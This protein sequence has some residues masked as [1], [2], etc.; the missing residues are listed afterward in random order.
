MCAAQRRP[1]EKVY[2]SQKPNSTVVIPELFIAISLIAAI[3]AAIFWFAP[4][5]RL[6]PVAPPSQVP[7]DL[8]IENLPNWLHE[9]EQSHGHVIE[10]AEATIEWADGPAVTDLCIL[11]VHGFSAT[12]QEIAP[13]PERVAGH[14]NANI[15][16]ARLAGHGLSEN[17]MTASAEHWLQ[18]M[19]DAWDIA[20]RIGK[21]VVIIAVSTGAPLSVWLNEQVADTDQVHSF[22]FLSPNF[23][24]RNPF[25]FLLTWPWAESWVPLIVGREHSWEPEN[26]LA[27]KYWTNRYETR[28]VIEM[29]KVVDWTA[30]LKPAGDQPP[31]ATLY[32]E[33]DP[34]I[35]HAAAVAFHDQWPASAKQ[36]HQVTLDADNPQHVF[37]GDITAPHRTDW[38]VDVCTRFIESL[39]AEA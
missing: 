17:P 26:E 11:Y 12:R 13:I 22:I 8:P 34:T 5:P 1:V 4:R 28:A 9:H 36:L 19:V 27:A 31:M 7:Q 20:S 24:I 6:D 32:M 37:A 25:G 15:L 30:K 21:R 35:N 14:F 38:C 23:R 33:N 16:H 3:L 39:P 10:G 29:Q 18:S 2:F